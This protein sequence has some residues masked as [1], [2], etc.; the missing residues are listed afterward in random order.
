M[1][2]LY[3]A[4][5]NYSSWS[6][7]PWVLMKEHNIAFQERIVPFAANNYDAFKQFAPNAKVPC[8]HDESVRIWDSMSICEYLAE[9]H[10]GLWPSDSKARAWAR[11]AAAEMHS[12]FPVLREVCTMNVGV[13]MRLREIPQALQQELVR[14]D[15]L[16]REGLECFSGPFLSGS[17][18]TIVDA[19]FAPVAFRWQTFALPL[20]DA[21]VA[22]CERILA[23]NSL[24]EWE[25][26]AIEETWREEAHEAELS[27]YADCVVDYRKGATNFSH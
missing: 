20:S 19:F 8:L 3:I 21:S 11:S 13:R 2:Q 27:A 26:E 22:Y 6:L 18:F 24:R 12:G 4:N 15:E 5:K 1:Y 7:R 16:W 25:R 14:I 17:E 23:L 10:S 9:R